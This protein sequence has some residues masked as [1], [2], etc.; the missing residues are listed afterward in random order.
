M[1]GPDDQLW[2]FYV[3]GD[4]DRLRQ[5]AQDGTALTTR[6][7]GF[8]GLAAVRSHDDATFE[9]VAISMVG[10]VPLAVVDPDIIALPEGGWRMFFLGV[11]A[12]AERV[13]DFET[14]R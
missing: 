1:V 10:E 4:T 2:L 3:D 5:R 9:E 13:N 8:A 11:A 12:A 6:L 7:P 14:D